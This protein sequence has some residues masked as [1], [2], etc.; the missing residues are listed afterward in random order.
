MRKIVTLLGLVVALAVPTVALAATLETGKFGDLIEEGEK[1]PY[2]AWYHFVNNQTGGATTGSLT[3]TFTNPAD[4]ETV[5]PWAVNQNVIHYYVWGEGELTGATSSNNG[6]SDG[7]LVLSH[8]G[9]G[10]KTDP[11]PTDD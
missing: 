9:C 10:K 11:I 8:I 3:A 4:T 2:G 7:K 1:C 6:S 5:G